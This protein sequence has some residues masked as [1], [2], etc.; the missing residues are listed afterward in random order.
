M[1]SHKH[2]RETIMQKMQT[3]YMELWK[4]LKQSGRKGS[5]FDKGQKQRNHK[6]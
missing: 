2:K 3:P 6:E 4:V 5:G 1:P